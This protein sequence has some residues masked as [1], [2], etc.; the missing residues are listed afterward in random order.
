MRPDEDMSRLR[1]RLDECACEFPRLRYPASMNLTTF[2]ERF[3]PVF[4]EFLRDKCLQNAALAQDPFIERII[5]YP[6]TLA[7]GEGKRIRPYM[8]WLMQQGLKEQK[9]EGT[10]ERKGSGDG[11]D[12]VM[13]M[14]LSLELFHVFALVHD[15]I[16]DR[17]TSRH[18]VATT[19]LMVA[20]ALRA[21]QRTGDL[22]HVGDAHAILLGDLLFQWSQEA[23]YATPGI[24]PQARER[25]A[26]YF[27]KMIEEVIV[28]QMMDVDLTTRS[29]VSDDF[30][31][32]K[33]HL[34]TSSY[35]F[36]RPLQIG[37]A[38]AGASDDVFA[39]CEQFGTAVGRAFQL[40]DD[41]LD[42][43]V[44]AHGTGKTAFS[45]LHERQH[46]LFTQYILTHGTDAQRAELQSLFGA[47]LTE[48]D[49]PRVTAL[50]E[51]SG[52]FAYG[53]K[54]INH[55][56]ATATHLVKDAPLAEHVGV[57]LNAFIATMATREA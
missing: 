9:D 40:Q 2:R 37:A 22:S 27:R 23:F 20:D 56:L 28:G 53:R 13:K 11:Q 1:M 8:A 7:G 4:A 41:L 18:G 6:E 36:I 48:A 5:H 38:L 57:A 16:M 44:P 26:P 34:K 46:T 39:W 19:H 24:D 3:Q 54:E 32:R 47:S 14:L 33:I 45:D 51:Q 43:T 50:F 31:E 15:D 10:K 12:Q 49:R 30:V 55:S 21:E 29:L 42:L 25:A 35:T 17:G 52:A